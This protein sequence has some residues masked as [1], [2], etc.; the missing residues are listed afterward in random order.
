MQLRKG[1]WQCQASVGERRL[2][3]ADDSAGSGHTRSAPGRPICAGTTAANRPVEH[4]LAVPAARTPLP[5]PRPLRSPDERCASA[6]ACRARLCRARAKFVPWPARRSSTTARDTRA[7]PRPAVIAQSRA[8]HLHAPARHEAALQKDQFADKT[9][10]LAQQRGADLFYLAPVFV[11]KRQMIKQVFNRVQ[12]G[13][14]E[15]LG[16]LRPDTFK[17]LYRRRQRAQTLAHGLA[18][19]SDPI[20]RRL[21][22]SVRESF[23]G[24]QYRREK[25]GM[26]R[27][28]QHE[29]KIF[30]GFNYHP[31]TLRLSKGELGVLKYLLGQR[32]HAVILQRLDVEVALTQI[33]D[34]LG[35]GIGARDGRKVRHL[36][37]QRERRMA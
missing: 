36:I 3:P 19:G 21:A 8:H 24:F 14:F 20:S 34:A 7:S 15:Q 31:F 10:F 12:A 18:D 23:R 22:M 37:I 28:A 25:I 6:P 33:F 29:R 2:A 9:F 5:P 17:K 13:G 27:P 35:G 11:A 32:G 4:K 1:R 26:L 16:A 30:L